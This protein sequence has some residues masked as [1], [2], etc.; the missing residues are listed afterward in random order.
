M[1]LRTYIKE[2][3]TTTYAQAY[4][5]E[6]TWEECRLESEFVIYIFIYSNNPNPSHSS[7]IP[8]IDNNQHYITYALVVQNSIAHLYT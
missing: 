2:E 1:Q 7:T 8:I 4:A 3:T 5:R 6:K